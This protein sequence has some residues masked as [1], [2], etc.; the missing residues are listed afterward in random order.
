MVTTLSFVTPID[1]WKRPAKQRECEG[2]PGSLDAEAAKARRPRLHAATP[3]LLLL[4]AA[5]TS[6]VCHRTRSVNCECLL[7]VRSLE[8]AGTQ[9][10]SWP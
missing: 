9:A 2:H 8:Y 4:E 1:T 7:S 10:L 3:V 6:G 5:G